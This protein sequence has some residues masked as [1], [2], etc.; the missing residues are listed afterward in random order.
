[1]PQLPATGFDATDYFAEVWSPDRQWGAWRDQP[2]RVRAMLV[3][4]WKHG[5]STGQPALCDAVLAAQ[6]AWGIDIHQP[7]LPLGPQGEQR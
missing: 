5:K 2:D 7:R 1:M 4:A 6:A 3:V